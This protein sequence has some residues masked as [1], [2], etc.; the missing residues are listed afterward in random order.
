MSITYFHAAE[1]EASSASEQKES[2]FIHIS[3]E[4]QKHFGLQVE[5]VRMRELNEYLQ[6]P[7]TVQ[8]IDSHVNPALCTRFDPLTVACEDRPFGTLRILR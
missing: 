6:V 1:A 2:G 5:P 4:A 7:G 8:P 3:A